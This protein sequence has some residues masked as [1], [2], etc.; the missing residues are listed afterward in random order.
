MSASDLGEDVM[1]LVHTELMAPLILE[2]RREEARRALLANAVPAGPGPASMLAV[3]LGGLLILIGGRLEAAGR[4]RAA[5]MPLT[6]LPVQRG[7]G[8]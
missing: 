7:R 6:L 3:Q 5:T 1:D 4:Q 2:E 8:Q